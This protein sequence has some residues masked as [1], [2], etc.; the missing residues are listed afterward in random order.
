MK[1]TQK[2]IDPGE[3]PE[4]EAAW[5]SEIERRI[6]EVESGEAETVG[7]DEARALIRAKFGTFAT[8]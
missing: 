2:D 4:V 1:D 8:R 5:A 6:V 3:D 7:W